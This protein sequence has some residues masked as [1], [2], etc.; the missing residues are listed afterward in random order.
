MHLWQRGSV[1]FVSAQLFCLTWLFPVS[2]GSSSLTRLFL[3]SPGSSRLTRLFPSHLALPRLTRLF[4]LTR[5]FPSHLALLI[6]PGSSCLTRLFLSHLAFCPCHLHSI[7][8]FP[9]C[10]RLMAVLLSITSSLLHEETEALSR[11]SFLKVSVIVKGFGNLT[12]DRFA[13]Q[14]CSILLFLCLVLPK[15]LGDKTW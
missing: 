14:T 8:S 6:S 1:L 10:S 13:L 4:C 15:M 9:F 7:S 2:P 3:V 12:L 11:D 5:L